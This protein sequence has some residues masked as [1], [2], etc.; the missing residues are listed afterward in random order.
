MSLGIAC[1]TTDDEAQA[2]EMARELDSIN[3]ER[4]TIEAEMREQAL[5]AME[6]QRRR[7]RHR[8]RVRPGWHQGVV[9]L[10]ASRLKEKFW[11]PHAGLRAGRRRR[12]RGSGRSIPDDAP[13]R[14]AGPWYPAPPT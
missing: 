1:L 6:E 10:V 12:D 4:R 7:R 5:A 2:L 14:R 3:R 11:R 9:G 13:A 8:L